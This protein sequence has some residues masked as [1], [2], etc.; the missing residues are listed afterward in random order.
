M[1]AASELR[2]LLASSSTKALVAPGGGTPLEAL[3]VEKAGFDAFYLS[4]YAV[5][6]WRHG[7]PDIG[8]LGAL[9]T[10][11]ALSAITRVTSIPIICDADTGYGNE[12]SVYSTVRLLEAAGAAAIQFEDQAWPKKCGH[13]SDKIVIDAGDAARKI[14]AAVAARRN[15]DTVI[16]ARTDSLGPLGVEEAIRRAKMFGEAGADILFVDA[17]Q[18][19]D[20][21]QMIG[22]ELDG[23]LMANMSESGLTPALSAPEFHQLGFSL[24]V[25]PTTALRVAAHS[26][27]TLFSVIKDKED[28][29]SLRSQMFGLDDLNDLVKLDEYNQIGQ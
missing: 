11:E 23:I 16:I 6:A 1:T 28:T 25:F 15:P 7:L 22:S 26:M 9:D 5:A 29:R 8:L 19:M 27:N 12:A 18:S 4:G 2:A 3:A 10:A 24:V 20:H 21:L 14:E 13:M 17:P